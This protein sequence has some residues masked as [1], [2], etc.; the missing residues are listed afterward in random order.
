MNKPG[1]PLF[2]GIMDTLAETC[3]TMEHSVVREVIARIGDNVLES[4]ADAT[5]TNPLAD[6]DLG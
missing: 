5:T 1:L 2:S 4:V 6:G 3:T